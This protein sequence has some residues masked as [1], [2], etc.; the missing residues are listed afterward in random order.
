MAWPWGPV[1]Q[2]MN[3]FTSVDSGVGI[4]ALI[5][6]TVEADQVER[7]RQARGPLRQHRRRPP[8]Y[9]NTANPV[10]ELTL[11][12][13]RDIYTGKLL[14]GRADAAGHRGRGQRRVEQPVPLSLHPHQ[15]PPVTCT[16][17]P[18]FFALNASASRA[19][20]ITIVSEP[21]IV[22]GLA[23]NTLVRT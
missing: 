8:V 6:G 21:V 19:F 18:V 7:S 10:K 9:L 4:A 20:M 11:A 17:V 1:A 22:T 3:A 16:N 15:A 13:I 5:N 14:A 12:Q 2:S 23:A